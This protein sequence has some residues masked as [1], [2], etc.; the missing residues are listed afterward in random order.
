MIAVAPKPDSS[1]L[2]P[3]QRPLALPAS[4][5]DSDIANAWVDAVQKYLLCERKQ[6]DLSAWIKGLQ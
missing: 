3:C 1:L 2:L 4:A 5:S 6:A